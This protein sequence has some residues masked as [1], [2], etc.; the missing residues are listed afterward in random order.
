[1]EVNRA[2]HLLIEKY[3]LRAA[4]YARIV[5]KG[6][7]TKIAGACI[8]V[9][10]VLQVVLSV[11][12]AGLDYFPLAEYQ[13]YSFDSAA[14]MR[15]RNI[16]LDNAIGAILYRVCKKLAAGEVALA[17]AVDKHAILNRTCQVGSL[18]L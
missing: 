2:A 7:L 17:I 12:S 8:H 10:H 16:K 14:I 13:A 6:E 1:G 9:Q 5:A 4:V 11:V 15:G 18:S 3:V